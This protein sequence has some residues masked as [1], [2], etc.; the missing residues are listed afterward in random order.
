[1]RL[2]AEDR[3]ALLYLKKDLRT[4]RP[5]RVVAV[6]IG[7]LA[8]WTFRTAFGV[9]RRLNEPA[10]LRTGCIARLTDLGNSPRRKLTGHPTL[11]QQTLMPARSLDPD[12]RFSQ[13]KLHALRLSGRRRP[14]RAQSRSDGSGQPI[15]AMSQLPKRLTSNCWINQ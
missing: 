7:C 14:E 13:G 9:A 5:T 4:D 3:L 6:P 1:M 12:L 8:Y 10:V 11:R 2:G 15:A